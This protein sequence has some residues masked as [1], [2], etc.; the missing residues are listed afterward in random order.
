M[1]TNLIKAVPI[2]LL[3]LSVTVAVGAALA[4][5]E[6]SFVTA[7]DA[8][9][10][11]LNGWTEFPVFTIDESLNGYTP[12]GILDGLAAYRRD[13]DAILV[14]ANHELRS[15]VGYAY[16]LANG[17]ELIGARVSYFD[18]DEDTLGVKD[19]G[20]A[21]DTIYN[22]AGKIVEGPQDLE[23]GAL[24]RLCSSA[25][26]RGGRLPVLASRGRSHQPGRRHRGSDGLHRS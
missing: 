15:N 20:L 9:M 25:G 18:I 24:N 7:A 16:T 3:A 13:D 14:I 2:P 10:T 8:Q 23:F 12:P 22:R 4:D 19:T 11:G 6:E 1:I 5:D 26:C 21:Y 17:A